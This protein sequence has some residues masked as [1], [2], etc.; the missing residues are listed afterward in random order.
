M[1]NICVFC[2]S[3]SGNDPVFEQSARQ[4]GKV[5]AQQ[6]M[7]LVYGGAKSGLMGILADTVLSCK[8][9]VIGIMPQILVD[10]EIVHNQLTY[11]HVVE[12][13]QERKKMMFD[14][15][16]GFLVLPGG[17]GTFDELSEILCL[18]QIGA[19]RAPIGLLNVNQFFGPWLD[20]FD[21][22]VDQGFLKQ[23]HRDFLWVDAD[24]NSLLQRMKDFYSSQPNE[25]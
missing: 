19:Y 18:V 1:K 15:A 2:G 23:E 21:H 12:N 20:L 24:L 3:R 9:E 17:T 4:V 5:I 25:S 16:D 10:Q 7:T 13:M 22:L 14:L 6:G 11:L 8:G